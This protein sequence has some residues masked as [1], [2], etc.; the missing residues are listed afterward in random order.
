MT[1]FWKGQRDRISQWGLLRT[2]GYYL[3]AVAPDKLGIKFLSAYELTGQSVRTSQLSN[4]TFTLLDS[5]EDWSA[6][7]REILHGFLPEKDLQL[8]KGFSARGDRCAVARCGDTELAC[9]CWIEETTKYCFAPGS[10]GFMIHNC[11]T[12]PEHRGK[13]LYPATLSFACNDLRSQVEAARIFIECSVVNYASQRGILKAGFAPLGWTINV[14]N[15]NWYWS[16]VGLLTESQFSHQKSATMSEICRETSASG[17][18]PERTSA[19]L[20]CAEAISRRAT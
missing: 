15:R 9:M 3:F 18:V 20:D 16:K 6:R 12:L 11:Y 2:L 8:F 7:D 19:A 14:R 1:G 17:E 13:G 10:R 5:A 4:A